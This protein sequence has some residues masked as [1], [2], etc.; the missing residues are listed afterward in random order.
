M[1][2]SNSAIQSVLDTHGINNTITSFEQAIEHYS[3]PT[4]NDEELQSVQLIDV[5]KA[6]PNFFNS[7]EWRSFIKSKAVFNGC[8]GSCSIAYAADRDV[9][10]W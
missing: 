5:M 8:D 9:G 2:I 3:N 6:D 4:V 1:D 10:G 7:E